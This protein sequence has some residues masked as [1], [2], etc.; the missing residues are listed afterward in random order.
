M[1]TSTAAQPPFQLHEGT[2]ARHF[3]PSMAGISATVLIVD[4]EE[5]TRTDLAT[6]LRSCSSNV[7]TA[8]DVREAL[9][10]LARQRFDVVLVDIRAGGLA[11]LRE[12]LRRVPETLI[13]LVT[14]HPTPAEAVEAMRA[15]AAEYIEKPRAPRQLELLLRRLLTARPQRPDKERQHLSPDSPSFL[16]STSP[17]MKRTIAMAR[18]A[19]AADV[20]VLL[21]GEAGTGKRVLARAIHEW[22]PHHAGPFVTV[23]CAALAEQY[24]AT[25]T[26]QPPGIKLV[27]P[28][29][30]GCMDTS[31]LDVDGGTLLFHD[32]GDLTAEL[33]GRL[34]RSLDDCRFGWATGED[35]DV[36]TRVVAA[37][38][39]DLE[40]DVRAGRFREDLFF[41]LNVVITVPP[42]RDR[43]EDL[44]ALTDHL[45]ARLTVRYRRGVM[46]L[47]PETRRILAYY[48]WPG[49]VLELLSVLERAV[50]L[51]SGDT[52]TASDLP[53]RLLTTAPAASA[54]EAPP[55]IVTLE[56][57]E[58]QHIKLAIAHCGTLEEAAVRLGIDPATLWRKRKRYGLS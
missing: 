55:P 25:R 8:S 51:T 2:A 11:L 54:A 18:Q 50:V 45:L 1:S 38:T 31:R 3:E 46:R 7:E 30:N 21:A 5:M 56:E 13:V 44:P 10:A 19:A 14:A 28:G 17:A 53:E 33:Q 42:L 4:P 57:V 20:P 27:G 6:H 41:R 32:V 34:V 47:A 39:H 12:I 24:A 48:R 37:T 40:A 23:A 52:I 58:R 43:E 26:P 9:A 49:N 22:S 35:T 16:E 29:T 15:G 36:D